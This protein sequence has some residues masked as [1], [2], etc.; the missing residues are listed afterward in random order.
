[1]AVLAYYLDEN[2]RMKELLISF[3]Q[4][5]GEHSGSNMAR[6]LIRELKQYDK[7]VSVRG[8]ITLQR[9]KQ[10]EEGY[11]AIKLLGIFSLL[12]YFI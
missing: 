11:L 3:N 1:M 7:G 10:G 9:L 12:D 2:W 8:D 5:R 6:H 4:L